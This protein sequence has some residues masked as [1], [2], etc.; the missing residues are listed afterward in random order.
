VVAYG[1]DT[2]SQLPVRLGIRLAF[3]VALLLLPAGA[4][5][6]SATTGA[7]AGVVKDTSGAILPG[8]TVEAASPAL[9]EKVRSAVTDGQGLY[10]IVGLRPGIYTVTFTLPGFSAVKREGLEL[11]AG[12]TLPVSGELRVGS[13]QG[14]INRDRSESDRRRGERAHPEHAHAGR[15]RCHPDRE[16][17]PGLGILTL[18][19]SRTALGDGDV[20]GNKG[21]TI[22]SLSIHRGRGGL[23]LVDG[24]R[25]NAGFQSA[26]SHFYQFNPI[27]AQEIVL[28][29]SGVSAETEIG[30]L[31]VNMVPKDG[32][33]SDE[34]SYCVTAPINPLLPTG[35]GNQI[36]Q[37]LYDVTPGKFGMITNTV[38]QAN[39]YG[40]WTQVYNGV[41]VSVAARFG[42]GGFVSGGISTGKT[43][44]NQC[45]TRLPA[46]QFCETT[47]P[48]SG[49]TQ[50]KFSG[51]YPLVWG[52]QASAT[53]QNVPGIPISASYAVLNAV[54]APSLGRN[55]A[56]CGTQAICTATATVQLIPA[57]TYFESRYSQL[58]VRLTKAVQLGRSRIR[59]AIDAYN[60]LNAAA[61]ISE[62]FAYG[63]SYRKPI[64]VLAARFVKFGL[65]L[66]F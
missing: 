59:P 16:E 27:A 48:W 55:L 65:Q 7:I 40:G 19:A 3:S 54:I 64:D 66:E 29:T 52:L 15:P 18:G 39:K 46:A 61:P 21:E 26:D 51:A 14:T 42:K 25:T 5:A 1:E 38:I 12:V 45:H 32:G 9:I 23:T 62:N 56:A 11:N 10:E 50:I 47:N 35:G 37:G 24:M 31:N 30:G 44:T 33:K 20:G 28:E 4:R 63:S 60:L 34:N 22:T 17:L 2:I 8:V 53:F 6:Q 57:N 36:C 41:D 13:L 49:Q 43:V 58:D